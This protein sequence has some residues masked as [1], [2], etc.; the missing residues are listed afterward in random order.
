MTPGDWAACA[1]PLL[2]LRAAWGRATER[3]LRLWAVACCRR[4]WDWDQRLF[5]GW[6]RLTGAACCLE[7]VELY[8]DGRLCGEALDEARAGLLPELR[9]EESDWGSPARAAYHAAGDWRVPYVRECGRVIVHLAVCAARRE[10]DL[11]EQ[12]Q[13]QPDPAEEGRRQADLLRDV[14]GLWPVRAASFDPAWRTPTVL[15]L[16]RS[17]YQ[18]RNW[19]ALPVLA[20]A[21]EDAGADDAALL[22]HLRGPG[23]H[24]RGCHAVDAV[25]GLG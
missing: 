4:L 12:G 7:A 11:A 22:D 2:M 21:L 5:W 24:T 8:A 3:Q 19:K 10:A 9:V 14:L 20:D 17:A 6:K 15:G 23:P 16:G 13:S 18:T 25:L 1:E